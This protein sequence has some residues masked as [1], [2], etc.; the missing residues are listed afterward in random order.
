ML[1]GDKFQL[2]V[3]KPDKDDRREDGGA[4]LL[5]SQCRAVSLVVSCGPKSFLTLAERKG[6]CMCLPSVNLIKPPFFEVVSAPVKSNWQLSDVHVTR[7]S[8]E[9]CNLVP[10]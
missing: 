9:S 4:V 10:I 6:P 2:V 1:L 3:G 5:P 7:M 8:S